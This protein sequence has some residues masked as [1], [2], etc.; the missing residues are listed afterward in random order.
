[1][2]VWRK[3]NFISIRT[4]K[5]KLLDE[6]LESAVTALNNPASLSEKGTKADAFRA[7]GIA[8]LSMANSGEIK[9]LLQQLLT[10]QEA[11]AIQVAAL[12]TLGKTADGQTCLFL[13]KEMKNFSPSLKKEAVN[14]FL[15]KPERINLL[16][17]AI[18]EKEVEKSVI[19]W[20]Q[21][22]RLMNY[23]DTNIR[24]Y[25]RKVLSVNEDRKA[26][27]NKYMPTFLQCTM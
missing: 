2:S 15:S 5:G 27:L 24:A 25:A 17:K 22:V 18:E 9:P 7:D 1:L 10:Q 14:V 23:Y 6:K 3:G 21:M 13:L 4:G 11:A 16:L 12:K 19:G 20:G 26:V 8:L